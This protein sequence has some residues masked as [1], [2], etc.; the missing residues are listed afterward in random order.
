MVR[1]MVRGLKANFMTRHVI[2]DA[3]HLLLQRSTANVQRTRFLE[4]KDV[5]LFMLRKACLA[6][7]RGY[8]KPPQNAAAYKITTCRCLSISVLSS[9]SSSS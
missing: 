3:Q 4:V 6:V 1:G 8:K 5:S 2:V 7:Y 9:G